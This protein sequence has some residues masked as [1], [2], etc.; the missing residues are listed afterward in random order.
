MNTSTTAV[1]S[2]W[3]ARDTDFPDGYLLWMPVFF[4]TLD[5]SSNLA[6]AM[7]LTMAVLLTAVLFWATGRGRAESWVETLFAFGWVGAWSLSSGLLLSS[8]EWAGERGWLWAVV[9]LASGTAAVALA[10]R[11]RQRLP[12]RA[13]GSTERRALAHRDLVI[14]F[15]A[16]AGLFLLLGRDG[17]PWATVAIFVPAF[18]SHLLLIPRGRGG[19]PQRCGR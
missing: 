7:V 4:S 3:C 6:A 16:C 8:T 2:W 19:R 10:W 13:A 18:L 12:M 17:L 5:K 1:R 11:H 14:W 9:G 15:S